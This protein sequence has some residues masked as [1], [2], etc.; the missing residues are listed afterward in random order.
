MVTRVVSTKMAITGETEYRN[1]LAKINSEIKT[2]Q[3]SLKLTESQYRNNANS[4]DALK[5]KGE[6]LTKLYEA[7]KTKVAEL[8][9]ALENARKAENEWAQKKADLTAKIE[10]NNKALEKLRNTAGDTSKEE[11]ALTAENKK[12]NEELANCDAKLSAAEKGTNNWQTQ[13]N[14]AEAKLNDLDGEIQKNNQYLE[15]AEKSSDNCADSI[16]EYGNEVHD[17]AEETISLSDALMA[18]GLVAALKK[19]GEALKACVDAAAEFEFAMSAVQAISGATSQE[20]DVLTAKAK[21]IGASTMY[22]A[23]EAADAMNYM[24]LAGWSATEMV[25]GIDGVIS[26][27]AASGEDLAQVCDIVTDSLTAFGLSASD[28]SGFVDVLAA[29]AAN[30]NTTVSMLGEAF[31]YAAPVAGALGYSIEDVSTAMG[32]MANNGIK[33]SMAGTAL[34]NMFTALSGEI[35]LTGSAIGEVNLRTANAD[36]SMRSLSSTLQDMRTYFSQMTEVEQVNNAQAI[37]GQ[38][39]YAGL[40]AILN[41]TEEDFQSLTEVIKESTGAAKTMAE[42]RMDNF[43]GQVTLM[44][45]AWD[46]VKIALG[47]QLLPALTSVTEA[48]TGVLSWTAEM[49]DKH[50]TLAPIITAVATALGVL[51]TAVAAYTLVQKAATI[52]MTAFTAIMAANPIFLVVTAV[53]ALAAGLGVLAISAK[54]NVTP[55]I[56]EL[57]DS[58]KNLGKTFEASADEFATTKTSIEGTASLAGTYIDRLSE[59]ERQSSMTKAEQEEYRST[60]DKLKAIMP[61]LNY[62]IDEQTGLLIGGAEAIRG[63]V[64][65]WKELA[66]QEALQKQYNADIEA[67]AEAEADAAIARAK[68]NSAEAEGEQMESQLSAVMERQMEISREIKAARDDDNLSKEEE[69]EKIAALREEYSAL[70]DQRFDLINGIREN[71]EE[72]RDLNAAVE[73]STEAIE[74]YKGPVEEARA[75]LEQYNEQLAANTEGQGANAEVIEGIKAELSELADYYQQVRDDAFESINSQIALF[76][77]FAASVSEDT[78]TV[79]EMMDIWARQ[80][81]NLAAYTENLKKAAEYGLDDGLVR[82]L[83]DGSTE[84]AGYLATIIGKIEELGGSTEGMSAEASTFVDEFNA[85]FARTVDAKNSFAD[86]VEAIEIEMDGVVAEL[87]KTAASVDFSGFAEAFAQAFGNVSVDFEKVGN[88][89][90]SG[91]SSGIET[92]TSQVTTSSKNMAQAAIDATKDTL[93]SHSDSQVMVRVGHDFVSGMDTGVKNTQP[94]LMSTVKSLSEEMSRTMHDS[95]TKMIKDFDTEFAKIVPNTRSKL[96]ELRSTIDSTMQP[97]PGNMRNIG[98]SMVDGMIG[99]MNSRSGALYSTVSSI[100]NSAIASAKSAAATAS[101]SKKTTKIFED[102]GEG[103]VVGLEHKRQKVAQTAHSVVDGAIEEAA[104][105]AAEISGE[106]K[107]ALLSTGDDIEYVAETDYSALMLEAQGLEEFLDL[108]A[109]R[110][111]KIAGEN[112]D[113]V[114]SGYRNNEQLLADWADATGQTMEELTKKLA[115]SVE[116]LSDKVETD[117][118]DMVSAFGDMADEFT[119]LLNSIGIAGGTATVEYDPE[120]DYSALMAEAED[121]EEFL[122]LAAKR[123]AKI[124]GEN[125][126]LTEKGWA[127]NATIMNKWLLSA[128]EN[129]NQIADVLTNAL[130]D[131]SETTSRATKNLTAGVADQ[132][133]ELKSAVIDTMK[134]M[135]AELETIAGQ[136]IDGMVKGLNNRS[137]VLY[138]TVSGIVESAIAKAKD[139]AATASPSKKTTAIFEDV[140]EGMIVGLEKKREKVARTAQSVVDQA[141]TLDISDRLNSA[142]RDINDTPPTMRILDDGAERSVVNNIDMEIHMD[143]VTI[144]EDA[145]IDRLSDALY[146]KVRREMRKRGDNAV[147]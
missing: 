24:A 16:D 104:K 115:D 105:A 42:I 76:D 14:N 35:V 142:L 47:E 119:N 134:T 46:G 101:P 124:L 70:E 128:K 129:I 144:R 41:S 147:W 2:L 43:T 132:T 9:S 29:T 32:L 44:Q 33:G 69:R 93:Q 77:D 51:A 122:E 15:K 36:G 139:A 40:L 30:S 136:M 54:S 85:S 131:V 123:N 11:A 133:K 21:E 110:S 90:G 4:M 106:L 91:L 13:L 1:S 138:S 73:E 61:D 120:I 79:E 86:T 78:D 38:R 113:L 23:K 75:A 117:V 28:T 98:T 22:T 84:S 72:Q 130:E 62:D 3:S 6:A 125:I 87:G 83:S 60:L 27:A 135:P 97:L 7:Q 88:D 94:Q 49:I 102:V 63:Q 19:T 17:A 81:E 100:V 71:A 143:G 58:V 59:L 37:A 5:S 52:A 67:Y 111:A 39:A 99:G 103:M 20:M 68:L 107:E 96:T 25:E 64:D 8:K 10:A 18:A 89:A 48:A 95:V 82:S 109:R 45:S 145:D 26:L 56:K 141:L 121:T 65:A 140:G 92:S 116:A 55:E 31:K 12:L 137:S 112:I 34:R 126:N 146:D 74:E 53:A 108:A 127:D 57:Q 66:I 114:A 80:T 50:Q 118:S